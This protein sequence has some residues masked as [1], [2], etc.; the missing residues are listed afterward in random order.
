MKLACWKGIGLVLAYL[1]VI[2]GLVL[3]LAVYGK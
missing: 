1:I 3:L 2:G